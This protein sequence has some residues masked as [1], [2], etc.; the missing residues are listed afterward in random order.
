MPPLDF[1]LTAMEDLRRARRS[2]VGGGGS[3]EDWGGAE[4]GAG[5]D[6]GTGVGT[7]T[8]LV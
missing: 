5:A 8:G 6:T 1:R 3:V 4:S 2:G 7:G